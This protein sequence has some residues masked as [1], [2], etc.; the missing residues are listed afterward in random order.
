[1][2]FLNNLFKRDELID[3]KLTSGMRADVELNCPTGVSVKDI[4][5][6]EQFL[7]GLKTHTGQIVTPEKARRCSAVIACMRI[8]S[9]D[10]SALPIVLWKRG[11]DGNAERAE[12]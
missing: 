12:N 9:E 4:E 7:I 2:T 6:M 11:K 10:L 1:M 8:I 3:L 5:G